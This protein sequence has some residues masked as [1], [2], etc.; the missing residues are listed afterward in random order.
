MITT[1]QPKFEYNHFKFKN[2][3]NNSVKSN[4][5]NHSK[6][7]FITAPATDKVSFTSKFHKIPKIEFEEYHMLSEEDKILLR[8]KC[9]NFDKN[10]DPNELFKDH[11]GLPL[12]NLDDMKEFIEFS[13][14]Y[15]ALK[16]SPILCL[17][18]SPKWPLSAS[19]WME[20]GIDGY[21]FVPF[22]KNWYDR[23]IDLKNGDSWVER[24]AD[25]APT[26]EQ[27][28]AYKKYLKI[29]RVDPKSIIKS[30]QKAGKETVITD[31]LETSRGMTSF[32]E[33][34]SKYAEE[35]GVLS[36]FAKSIRFFII[37]SNEYSS[38]K[39][40]PI[41]EVAPKPKVLFPDNLAKVIPPSLWSPPYPKQECHVDLSQNVFE[42][43]F[44]SQNSNESRSGL[45]SKDFW[46]SMKP[47]NLQP[48]ITQG[49]KDYR[50]LLNFRILDYLNTNNLLRKL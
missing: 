1:V 28:A 42:Q 32:L 14:K 2:S 41:L 5:A 35:Q 48:K 4:I 26:P 10:V 20:G 25:R 37:G 36:E 29:I 11:G 50:N 38:N 21:T 39:F 23:H 34:L 13:S 16:G 12:A 44:I 46:M 49:M 3:Q 47:G 18:R 31:Y 15:N 45:Y 19:L 6:F 43:M 8:E 27:E 40:F 17:G 7:A 24:A 22:S 30:T 33:I 9:K